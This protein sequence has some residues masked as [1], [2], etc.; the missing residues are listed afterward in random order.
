MDDVEHAIFE[1]AG[2]MEQLQR[3]VADLLERVNCADEQL[4]GELE[5]VLDSMQANA[6]QLT[7]I[8][9]RWHYV[10]R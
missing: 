5:S 7:G 6:S 4:A 1:A 3:Q 8:A 9:S 2:A 10:E